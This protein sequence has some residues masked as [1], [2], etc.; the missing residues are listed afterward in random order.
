[1]IKYVNLDMKDPDKIKLIIPLFRELIQHMQIRARSV[2]AFFHKDI[3]LIKDE[4]LLKRLVNRVK[5]YWYSGCISAYDENTIA[6]Y[7]FFFAEKRMD[8]GPIMKVGEVDQLFV[9]EE[10]RKKHLG[11]ELLSK[12]KDTLTRIGCDHI[13]VCTGAGNEDVLE[14]YKN[15][16]F[17]LTK[18]CLRYQK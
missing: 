8:H 14:F 18:Y 5:S 3:S 13:T 7:S 6:G 4:D 15:G 2:D 16:G 17:K 10:Y 1:M 11:T 9:K 12:T